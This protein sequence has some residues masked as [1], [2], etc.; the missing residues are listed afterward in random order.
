MKNHVLIL[1]FLLNAFVLSAFATESL[2]DMPLS[3]LKPP[4]SAQATLPVEDKVPGATRADVVLQRDIRRDILSK[5]ETESAACLPT[6]KNT[7]VSIPPD[8]PQYNRDGK[9]IKGDWEELWT[10]EACGKLPEFSVY[11]MPD[12]VGGTY[13]AVEAN[14]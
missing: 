11:F 8:N 12:G 14:D 7:K 13:F 9:L 3:E 2:L 4:V 1:T 6:I 5:I 10:V